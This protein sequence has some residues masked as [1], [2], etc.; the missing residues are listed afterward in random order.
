M[1]R[2]PETDFE[3]FAA[4]D[5]IRGPD[6]QSAT[7]ET[8]TPPASR[9]R[10]QDSL[11]PMSASPVAASKQSNPVETLETL[12]VAAATEETALDPLKASPPQEND[13][14]G[15]GG[16]VVGRDSQGQSP[17]VSG[18]EI[19]ETTRERSSASRKSSG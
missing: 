14:T 10:Q 9:H 3:I 19:A 15:S 2:G 16:E 13:K 4:A 6:N 17:A 11:A 7:V 18:G 8:A 12:A 5:V 1:F